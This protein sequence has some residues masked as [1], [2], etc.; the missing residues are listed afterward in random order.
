MGEPFET[1][2]VQEIKDR[3]WS[4][5]PDTFVGA[6]GEETGVTAVDA[7]EAALVPAAFDAVIVKVYRSP[8]VR[9]P[10]AQPVEL[11]LWEAAEVE[12]V[13]S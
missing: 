3:P 13:T 2:G 12:V 4:T 10:M 7:S 6:P 8:F 5:L 11:Q 1:E 9:P